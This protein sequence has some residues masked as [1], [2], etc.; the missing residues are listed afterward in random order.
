[1]VKSYS[2]D[3][4]YELLTLLICFLK[5][6]GAVNGLVVICWCIGNSMRERPAH[7]SRPEE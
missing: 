6:E 2:Q 4:E 3:T 5:Q 1:M 7:L